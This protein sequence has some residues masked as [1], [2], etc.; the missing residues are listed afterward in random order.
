M[1][2][3]A[4]LPNLNP[5]RLD[6]PHYRGD[7]LS[8]VL[9]FRSQG[10]PVDVSEWTFSAYIRTSTD[11]AKIAEFK[12]DMVDPKNGIIRLVLPYI[13]ARLLPASCVWDLEAT[14]YTTVTVTPDP[15][16]DP[17][18]PPIQVP[19]RVRTLLRGYIYTP[20]DVTYPDDAGGGIIDTRAVDVRA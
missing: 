19:Y 10:I 13:T 9:R 20:A 11:G 3:R 7:S 17:P 12:P 6:I 1:P 14:E 8:A 2:R 15:P 5:A 16:P 4:E 18:I